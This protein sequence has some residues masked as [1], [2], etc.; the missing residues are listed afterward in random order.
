MQLPS[1][2]CEQFISEHISP[3]PTSCDRGIS[4][5]L[6]GP[7]L[8]SSIGEEVKDSLHRAR[9]KSKKNI[10]KCLK[11]QDIKKR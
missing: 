10:I 6:P 8:L 2:Q 1:S 9:E 4:E 3:V 5:Y 7:G 11:E